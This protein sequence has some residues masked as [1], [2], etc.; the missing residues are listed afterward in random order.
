MTNYTYWAEDS[1]EAIE[2]HGVKGQKWGIKNGPPYPLKKPLLDEDNELTDSGSKKYIPGGALRNA[3]KR[4]KAYEKKYDSYIKNVKQHY[5]DYQISNYYRFAT[6]EEPIDERPKYVSSNNIEIEDYR[7]YALQG[8]LGSDKY[9]LSEFV[10]T[11]IKS[12]QKAEYED[13]LNYIIDKYGSETLKN[14][15]NSIKNTIGYDNLVGH[16]Y[17]TYKA[18][19]VDDDTITEKELTGA[20]I[21]DHMLKTYRDELKPIMRKHVADITSY[22]KELGYDAIPDIEDYWYAPSATIIL[23]PVDSIKLVKETPIS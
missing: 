3:S 8:E 22:Y 4:I 16:A 20:A 1:S 19:N 21:V 10:Y 17:A 9:D 2:H 14:V 6:S 13:V 5:D 18:R 7:R 15:T 23:T 11:P 12:I